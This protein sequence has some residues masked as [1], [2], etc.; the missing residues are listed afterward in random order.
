[1][2]KALSFSNRFDRLFTEDYAVAHSLL[3][4]CSASNAIAPVASFSKAVAMLNEGKSATEIYKLLRA[5]KRFRELLPKVV[6]KTSEF[7]HPIQR[8]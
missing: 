7:K 6:P 3:V 1:M 8:F 5:V 4:A 2:K